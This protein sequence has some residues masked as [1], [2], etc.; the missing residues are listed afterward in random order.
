MVQIPSKTR[1]NSRKYEYEI[2]KSIHEKTEIGV[3][4]QAYWRGRVCGHRWY[5]LSVF[6]PL[7]VFIIAVCGD[8][9]QISHMTV[10]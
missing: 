7:S 10:Y 6:I 4:I 3:F 1:A 5:R 9:N 8:T 2:S